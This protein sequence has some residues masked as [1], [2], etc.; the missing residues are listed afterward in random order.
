MLDNLTQRLGRVVKNLRGQARLTEDNISDMLRDAFEAAYTRQFSRVI[1]GA[2]LEILNWSVRL[3][4]ANTAGGADI[5]LPSVSSDIAAVARARRVF[6]PQQRQW[7][8]VA[9]KRRSDMDAGA[10]PGPAL[11]A[12]RD[13]TTFVT[14]SFSASMGPTGC[15]TLE[16]N[17]PTTGSTP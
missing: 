12:E 9:A 4:I 15:I 2:P 8:Q 7:S 1:P 13:T 11:V 16:S 5:A 17:T 10:L 14:S 6:D 3:S